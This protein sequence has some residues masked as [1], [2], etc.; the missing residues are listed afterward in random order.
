M[1]LLAFPD[2]GATVRCE[3]VTQSFSY[4]QP[5]DAFDKACGPLAEH[6]LGLWGNLLRFRDM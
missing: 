4:L 6:D 5:L 1:R 2:G 3:T